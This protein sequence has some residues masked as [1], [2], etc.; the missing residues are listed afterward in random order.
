MS[1]YVASYMYVAR[2]IKSIIL[3]LSVC[4]SVCLLVCLLVCL[5]VTVDQSII[6]LTYNSVASCLCNDT[7]A[8]RTVCWGPST[9]PCTCS[10]ESCRVSVQFT[11]LP[12]A[13]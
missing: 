4:L 11:Q 1:V 8:V 9:A 13:S 6:L 10:A 5:S 3:Q 12:I 7:D 2:V